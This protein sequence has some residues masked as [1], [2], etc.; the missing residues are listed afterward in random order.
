[1]FA[2]ALYNVFI[3]TLEKPGQCST[4]YIDEILFIFIHNCK[5]AHICVLFDYL[6]SHEM[7][8]GVSVSCLI[9][10]VFHEMLEGLL[11]CLMSLSTFTNDYRKRH[12]I[13]SDKIW[14]WH[15]DKRSK[16]LR[17]YGSVIKSVQGHRIT[18]NRQTKFLYRQIQGLTRR[19]KNVRHKTRRKDLPA[20]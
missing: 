15:A 20:K 6:C 14:W 13:L 2:L 3:N 5:Q 17:R 16:K 8:E 1:M 19:N 7:L 12:N 11:F 18:R 9:I 10:Y 4:H